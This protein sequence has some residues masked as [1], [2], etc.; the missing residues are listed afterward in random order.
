VNILEIVGLLALVVAGTAGL[1]WALGVLKA[2][3]KIER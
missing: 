3:V 1:L 2:D